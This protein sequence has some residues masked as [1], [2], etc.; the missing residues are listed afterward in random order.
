MVNAFFDPNNRRIPDDEQ[1]T[2]LCYDGAMSHPSSSHA[3][4]RFATTRWSRI[5]G[6][7]RREP[8]L[9]AIA[10]GELVQAYWYPL[11]VYI[12]RR[13]VAR[14]DAEDLT[15]EFF[16]HLL[17]GDRLQK[18]SP[19][20]GRFRNFLLASLR[21]FMSNQWRNQRTQ[22]RGGDATLVSL[23]FDDAEQR[24][25][26]EPTDCETPQQLF[27]RRWALTLMENALSRVREFYAQR[28]KPNCSTS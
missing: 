8:Q 5:V 25:S 11:Y 12:R 23:N 17:D 22:K 6:Q 26:L 21:N 19:E 18:A 2:G 3:R 27:D 28:A 14:E 13:G 7:D 10:F 16:A 24:Y 15:Q 4:A 1:N 20:R 9:R